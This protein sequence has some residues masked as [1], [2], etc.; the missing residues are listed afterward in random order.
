M[1]YRTTWLHSSVSDI[2]P[3]LL[4]ATSVHATAT[5][6]DFSDPP[7]SVE[8]DVIWLDGEVHAPDAEVTQEGELPSPQGHIVDDVRHLVV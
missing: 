8:Y 7:V 6:P 1:Y 3:R 2:K 4:C 5:T